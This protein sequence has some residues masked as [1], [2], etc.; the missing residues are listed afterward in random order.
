MGVWTGAGGDRLPSGRGKHAGGSRAPGP[1]P[2]PGLAAGA[3]GSGAGGGA[4]RG[5]GPWRGR[6]IREGSP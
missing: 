5:T 2:G 4:A 6:P 3:A 1:L